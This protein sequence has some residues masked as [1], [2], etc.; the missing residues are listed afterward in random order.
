MSL[1]A[2]KSLAVS[3][4]AASAMIGAPAMAASTIN[5]AVAANFAGAMTAL[6]AQFKA[7]LSDPRL[8]C[9]LYCG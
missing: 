1:K 9:H 7:H 5:V 3:L 2:C 4:I 8:Q 6:I